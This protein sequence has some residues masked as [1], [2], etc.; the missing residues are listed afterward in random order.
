MVTDVPADDQQRNGELNEAINR[1]E[2]GAPASGE[3]VRD[4]FSLDEIFQ[5]VAASANEE[6][7]R[8]TRLLFLG[9]LAAGLSIGLSFYARAAITSQVPEAPLIG[10]LIYP[11]G[12]LLI[13]VGRYQLFTENTLTPV[14]LVLTRIASV[15]ALL[16]NWGVVLSANVV[17]AALLAF[18]LANTP[19]FQPEAAAYALDIWEHAAETSWN[20]LFFKGIMAGWL[21]ASMVW[22]VHAARDTI[23]R[24]FLVFIIMFL[25]PSGDLFHCI[26]GSCEAFYA[27][28]RGEAMLGEAMLGFFAPVLI[29][30]TIGGVLLVAILNYAQTN[31]ALYPEVDN[32]KIRLN[33]REWLFEFHTGAR[34]AK[35]I[36]APAQK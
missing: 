2:S 19:I 26:I 28:F 23:T 20:A 27:V 18:V 13:V 32:G 17:G 8:P 34:K 21:V 16:R 11:I 30:N 1:S 22:L 4:F 36:I 6:F 5:R 29:G 25:I 7:K 33:W 14:T 35:S 10:N 31:E 15:P 12:F 3:A 24:V 9:G